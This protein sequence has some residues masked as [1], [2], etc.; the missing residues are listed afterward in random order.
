MPRTGDSLRGALS[1]R[2]DGTVVLSSAFPA[3]PRRL[4][5]A[6]A[7]RPVWTRRVAPCARLGQACLRLAGCRRLQVGAAQPEL[8]HVPRTCGG[9]VLSRMWA[10]LW[11]PRAHS[12]HSGEHQTETEPQTEM[13]DKKRGPVAKP[14]PLPTPPPFGLSPLTFP[15]SWL[16]PLP[17][18]HS[19]FA[20]GRGRGLLLPLTLRTQSATLSQDSLRTSW[21][22]TVSSQ[23]PEGTSWVHCVPCPDP[24]TPTCTEN[25]SRC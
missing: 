21:G 2:P 24:L 4:C 11:G 16:L 12:C 25:D 18:V 23:E 20:R 9:R 8:G 19:M 10:G 15:E 13:E 22:H 14:W 3:A 7:A 1:G 5:D 6:K 17:R